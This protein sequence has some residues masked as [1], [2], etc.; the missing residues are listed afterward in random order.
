MNQRILIGDSNPQ[1]CKVLKTLLSNAGYAPLFAADGVSLVEQACKHQPHLLILD[2]CLPAG[3]ANALIQ[4]I[5]RFPNF[6]HLPVFITAGRE[7]RLAADGVFEAGAN[8]FLPKPFS[9][10]V[11]FSL[12]ARFLPSHGSENPGAVANHGS[13][14]EQLDSFWQ[15]FYQ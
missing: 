3:N 1:V 6:A 12:I 8:A 11:L 7:H 10:Q 14:A 2:L 9:R 15:A 4:S 5:R 13:K